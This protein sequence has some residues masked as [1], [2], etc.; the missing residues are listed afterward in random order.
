MS[1]EGEQRKK[2][3]RGGFV[4]FP[5][6]NH[7]PQL[8][9]GDAPGRGTVFARNDAEFAFETALDTLSGT[10]QRIQYLWIAF[11][12]VMLT[13]AVTTANVSH[14]MLLLQE[15]V[16]LP[17]VDLTIPLIGYAVVGPA[18]L[19]IMH[20]YLLAMLIALARTVPAFDAAL[21]GLKTEVGE[22]LSEAERDK[23]RSRL[24]NALF[25]LLLVGPKREREGA[26]GVLYAIIALTTVALAPIAVLFLFQLMFLPYQSDEITWWHRVAVWMDVAMVLMLWPSYRWY[27]GERFL[28]LPH[29]SLK[30]PG[31]AAKGVLIGPATLLVALLTLS[32]S[33]PCD[34]IV[35]YER[36]DADDPV[37]GAKKGE[38]RTDLYGK[39]IPVAV[40]LSTCSDG[41]NQT[42]RYSS[43]QVELLLGH[44]FGYSA[45][46]EPYGPFKVW[47]FF[48]NRLVL[49]KQVLVDQELVKQLKSARAREYERMKSRRSPVSVTSRNGTAVMAAEKNLSPS[50]APE[51]T[52]AAGGRDSASER[53][54]RDFEGRRLRAADFTETD[55]TMSDFRDADLTASKLDQTWLISARFDSAQL[56]YSD[57]YQTKMHGASFR[58][59]SLEGA[60]LYGTEMHGANLNEANLNFTRITL[61]KLQGASMIAS[62]LIR[63]QLNEVDMRLVN[64]DAIIGYSIF[65]NVALDGAR[66]SE[67]GNSS[68]VII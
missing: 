6:V 9:G 65:N 17:L 10:A 51:Q 62:N 26:L 60:S 35:E 22:P 47:N 33:F 7:P 36:Y 38:F 30:T 5:W 28:R 13:F 32:A 1:G 63:A 14:K 4:R 31:A 46:D 64:L 56:A 40:E 52:D 68:I 57:L 44:L 34:G 55:L 23:L 45:Q 59:A 66:V 37:R 43:R 29:F 8:A 41:V 27:R 16:K 49:R 54:S 58:G 15:G 21:T 53:F 18:L 3:R 50:A 25:A 67:L 39:R 2:A 19:L 12:T 42:L 11:I 61:A 24:G 20:L 48:D